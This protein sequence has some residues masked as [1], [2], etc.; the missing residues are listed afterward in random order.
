MLNIGLVPLII[1]LISSIAGIIYHVD[2][3]FYGFIDIGIDFRGG[4]VLTIEMRR[5]YPW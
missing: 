5:R 4:T 2:K 3:R 1:I